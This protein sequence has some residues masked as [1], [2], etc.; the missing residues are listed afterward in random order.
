MLTF[1]Y[2]PKFSYKYIKIKIL[3]GSPG[4]DTIRNLGDIE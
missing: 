4:I 1:R 3:V 2:S